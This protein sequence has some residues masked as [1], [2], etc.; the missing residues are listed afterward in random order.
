[1]ANKKGTKFICILILF[2]ALLLSA[3]GLSNWGRVTET[4]DLSDYGNFDGIEASDKDYVQ[5]EFLR[6]FP[7]TIP[8]TY[9]NVQYHFATTDYGSA[10]EINLEFSIP[11]EDEFLAYVETVAPMEEFHTFPYDDSYL[12]YYTGEN[13]MSFFSVDGET[14]DYAKEGLTFNCVDH[15]AIKRLL[16]NPKDRTVVIVYLYAHSLAFAS[17]TLRLDYFLRRFHI[18]PKQY[19]AD[20]GDGWEHMSY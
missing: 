12:E 17:E 20:Y 1:M 2:S 14:K 16:I 13:Y 6:I 11:D 19:A 5:K 4:Y 18:D 8:P 3:C 15:A 7:Q 10:Y 9:E